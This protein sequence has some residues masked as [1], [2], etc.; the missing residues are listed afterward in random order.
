MKK[1]KEIV[2]I[3]VVLLITLCSCTSDPIEQVSMLKKIVEV[4]ADGS[5][6]TT[7]LTY[8]G[9][10][11]VTIDKEDQ[12]SKFYYTDDL[13]TK[14][15]EFDK[16]TQHQNTLEYS[17]LKGQLTK[18]TSSDNYVIN[19]VHNGDGSVSY[20]KVTKVSNNLEVKNY[21]GILYFQ[22]ENLVKDERI[23]DD[24]GIGILAK[25]TLSFGYDYKKN[26]LKNILG[27]NKLLNYSKIISSNNEVLGTA[28]SS[29]KYVDDNQVISEIKRYDS[30]YQYNS[31]GYPTEIVSEN[32]L[33]GG[34]DSNHLKS[35]LFY[36]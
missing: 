30:E 18:I 24:A 9:N 5:S 27:F 8:D 3:V 32:I 22:N 16:T 2:G 33:F 11:L 6:N 10:K 28:V 29:I 35:Q 17:Y 31:S 1:A 15:V 25:N 4:S 23:L 21:H 12:L 19:Y 34:S 13:I 20:E 36:N 7:L 14:V 26:A